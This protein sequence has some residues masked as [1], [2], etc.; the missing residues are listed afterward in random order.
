MGEASLQERYKS[1]MAQERAWAYAVA[2]AAIKARPISVW[3]VMVPV[4]LI[5]SYMHSQS[6]RD[7]FV[8]NLLFTKD[9]ALKAALE[10]ESGGQSKEDALRAV[11]QKTGEVLAN[12]RN[13]IYSEEIRQAQLREIDLLVDHYRRL[14][15]AEGADCEALILDAYRQIESYG[16]FMDQLTRAEG[17]VN[18]ASLST[19]GEKGDPALVSRMEESMD[20][21]RRDAAVRIFETAG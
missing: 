15:G 12:V 19:L 1:I 6:G 16:S 8:Q 5:F 4:L 17:D 11:E 14:L 9:L 2:R 18:R 21:F 13:G 7:V 10:I 3:E 20:R